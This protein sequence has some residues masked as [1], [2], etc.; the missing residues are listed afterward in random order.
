[1]KFLVIRF[2]SY[3]GGDAE[4][5]K[6]CLRS[7]DPNL[8]SE[9]TGDTALHFAAFNGELETLK[10]LLE[11]KRTE[12]NIQ[13]CR[14]QTAAHVAAERKQLP[15]LLLLADYADLYSTQD[16]LGRSVVDVSRIAFGD[17]D[18]LPSEP[19][20]SD[21]PVEARRLRFA[22]RQHSILLGRRLPIERSRIVPPEK[23]FDMTEEGRDALRGC[24]EDVRRT[25]A[26]LIERCGRL[27]MDTS[28][29]CDVCYDDDERLSHDSH[30]YPIPL[31]G[32]DDT[33]AILRDWRGHALARSRAL[34]LSSARRSLGCTNIFLNE[35]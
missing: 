14:L 5:M 10:I 33:D 8:R 19:K 6:A 31:H 12:V 29:S 27:S 26:A 32:E 21:D 35:G 2:A 9:K 24:P 3:V 15:A 1:M 23:D 18:V 20:A 16:M 28:F 30:E 17:Q 13:N 22:K 25:L 7:V 4:S 34:G 11:D